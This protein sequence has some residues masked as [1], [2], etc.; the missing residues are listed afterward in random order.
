MFIQPTKYRTLMSSSASEQDAGS[1]LTKS[2]SV[3]ES[4]NMG[5]IRKLWDLC[6]CCNFQ[7]QCR[8]NKRSFVIPT[9]L[10]VVNSD[11][12]M[13]HGASF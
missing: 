7:N 9:H 11:M 4:V 12:L 10:L 2:Q 13:K 3:S 6:I 1:M 8:T 5:Y